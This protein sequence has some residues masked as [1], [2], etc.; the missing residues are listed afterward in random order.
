MKN[1]EYYMSLPYRLEVTP[2]SDEGGYVVRYPD[3]PGCLSAGNTKQD[4]LANAKDAKREWIIA[5]LE[6]G[7]YIAEPASLEQ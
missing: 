6:E 5:A 1:L 4:A 3:L 2:D 7:V